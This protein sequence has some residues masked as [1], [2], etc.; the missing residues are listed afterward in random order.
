M[1]INTGARR[2]VE[3]QTFRQ[4]TVAFIDSLNE[5]IRDICEELLVPVIDLAEVF[6]APGRPD[7]LDPRYAIGD[8]AH[9]NIDGQRRIAK[10]MMDGYFREAEDFRVV[11]CL[12]DSHTQGFP[13]R[14]ASRNGYVIDIEEDS[15]H[16]FPY[17]LAKGTGKLFINRGIAGNTIYGLMRRF[18]TEVLPHYPDHCIIQGGTNDSLL[19]VPLQDSKDD[20]KKVIDNC[21]ESGIVPIVGTVV[22]LGFE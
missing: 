13:I 5:Y 14:D 16:Q 2:I 15:P 12:G 1:E 10:A 20:L 4:K 19:G 8:N 7:L 6:G 3:V 18:E 21:T 9:L 17:W 22:P 11:V